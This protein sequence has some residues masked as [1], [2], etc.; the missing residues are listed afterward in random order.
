MHRSTGSRTRRTI[1]AAVALV[2]ALGACSSDDDTNA[3]A[4]T[5]TAPAPGAY[6]AA[7]PYDVGVRTFELADGN[8]VEVWYPAAPD[9]TDGVEPDTY[10]ISDWLPEGIQEQVPDGVDTYTTAAF[11]DVPAHD[12]GPFPVVLFSHG[13]ASFRTQS[14]FLTQHLASWGMV[15]AAPDHPSRGLLA[16]FTGQEP[17]PNA[18]LED[19][20]NTVRFLDAEAA[21]PQWPLAGVLDL[22]ALAIAG[23]SAG[24]GTALQVAS[25][26]DLGPRLAMYVSHASGAFEDG[27]LPDVPSVFMFGTDDD[28]VEPE[29]TRDAYDRAPAPKRL[30]SIA[31][32]GHLAFADIC[33]IG[34][35]DGG[36]LGL[37]DALGIE[38]PANLRV[39]A[40]DGCTP[41]EVPA[42][43]TWPA[44]NHFT[45]ANLRV[46]FGID[47]PDDA[48]LADVTPFADLEIETSSG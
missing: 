15:V 7:G 21:D 43:D 1:V 37:A 24:G 4:T 29:R 13:F 32:A 3:D 11:R 22:D 42:P 20:R 41:E 2:T 40:T 6:A 30:Y 8:L 19:I 5:T 39:L 45:T 48:Q 14:T 17:D 25:D 38:V 23:H 26:P 27:A 47:D 44:I 46:A 34:A 33:E 9:S 35:D 12:D 16:V 18:S 31:G 10:A 28:I 36:V